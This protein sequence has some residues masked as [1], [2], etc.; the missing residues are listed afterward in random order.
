M[1]FMTGKYAE[2][3]IELLTT[4]DARLSLL[5][6]KEQKALKKDESEDEDVIVE[7]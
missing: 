6:D 7:G 5:T 2:K 1:D 4:I 3:I